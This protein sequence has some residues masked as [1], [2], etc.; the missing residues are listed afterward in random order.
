[1]GNPLRRALITATVATAT[2][3]AAFGT[4]TPAAAAPTTQRVCD[5]P[6]GAHARSCLAVRRTG[7][8][9]AAT[10]AY[11]PADL[12]GAYK[13]PSGGGA[14]ATIAIVD[15]YDDPHAASDL[16]K[17]RSYYGLPALASGQFRKVNQT[18]GTSPL[19]AADE[20]WAGEISLDLDMVSAVAPKANIILVEADSNYDTDLFAAVDT[21]VRL[22]AKY[23]SLSWGGGED[24]SQTSLDSHL[25]H[26]GVAITASTG[27]YG[28]GAS[29]P[30]TSKYVTA[31]G[32][33]S[34]KKSTNSRGWSETAWSG[35]GSGCSA[36]DAKPA[37]QTVSTGC[38]KR[39]EADVA[40][41]ADP[42]TGV[43][44]Y[45]TYGGSGWYV[46][47][48]TSASAPIIASVYALAGKTTTA[49]YPA[50]YP[51]AHASKL[52]DVTSG[53]N[54]SC[55]APMCTARTGWDGPTG[56]GTPNGTA[57]F[58][59]STVTVK[60]PGTQAN[61]VADTVGVQLS[62]SGGAGPYTWSASNLP[63]GLSISAA[64]KITGS[65]T[66][67]GTS[68]V[69]VTA[70]D[71]GGRTAST[72]FSWTVRT[73]VCAA[74]QLLTNP[75]FEN[76]AT[77]WTTG[78]GVV[79]PDGVD[80]A[81]HSGSA[82][83]WLDGYGTTHT[84]TLTQSV[85]VPHRCGTF[86]VSFQLRVTTEEKSA[87]PYDTLTVKANSTTLA[88][89]SNAD[90]SDGYVLR[91]FTLTGLADTTV[92][93]SFTGTEDSSVPTSFLIDDVAADVS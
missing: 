77:G 46:Y 20:G 55:G 40:A 21:A 62:A 90:A 51:Y 83:A 64:G 26:P 5:T 53:S 56:L 71:A 76:G 33:T 4:A 65:P 79:A 22:G 70:R 78:P 38:G 69:T 60:N 87:S 9:P 93:L 80:N 44:V 15:A 23:V 41:V 37:W 47:G 16:A 48:G 75:G 74:G 2:G 24:S 43:A 91:T 39:A 18:G 29:Y 58:A 84:D 35:A 82:Y 54:G 31:V 57:A 32:G 73:N 52:F 72:S 25:N 14:G 88:T 59:P 36:Y 85:Q 27:D 13:L 89:Y 12:R 45:Q 42:N 86:T 3:L 11:G 68:T 7:I 1:M 92:T 28:T 67:V 81:A 6:S 49:D 8:Q 50:A 34:L 17:Y 61:D 66:T 10:I 30:A 63:A 19:P